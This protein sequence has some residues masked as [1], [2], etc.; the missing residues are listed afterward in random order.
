MEKKIFNWSQVDQSKLA[1]MQE[2]GLDIHEIIA[3]LHYHFE[4][5]KNI[6]DLICLTEQMGTI[7]GVVME[8]LKNKNERQFTAVSKLLGQFNLYEF[9]AKKEDFVQKIAFLYF[10]MK[11][12]ADYHGIQAT[13]EMWPKEF[14]YFCELIEQ[15]KSTE[16]FK[17]FFIDIKKEGE[18][19]TNII[20]YYNQEICLN[21]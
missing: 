14:T 7:Q 17:S 19:F 18:W 5:E 8:T 3:F 21:Q 6:E 16:L 10:P 20:D 2:I 15:Y 12:A 1:Q 9:K 13:H 4:E 11:T